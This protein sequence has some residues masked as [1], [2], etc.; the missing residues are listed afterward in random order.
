MH[1]LIIEDEPLVAADIECFLAELGADSCDFAETQDEAVAAATTH[2]PDLITADC[3]LREGTGPAAVATIRETLGP[4]PVVYITG[5]PE[6]CAARD[7][8]THAV[9]KPIRWLDL[10]N[11]VSRYNLPPIPR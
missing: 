6:E 2:L 10:A 11:A 3:N 1:V 5:D 8:M 7:P 9:P 4:I